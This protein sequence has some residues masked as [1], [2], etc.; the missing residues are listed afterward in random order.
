MTSFLNTKC[1]PEPRASSVRCCCIKAWFWGQ[2]HRWRDLSFGCRSTNSTTRNRIRATELAVDATMDKAGIPSGE[3]GS[4]SVRQINSWHSYMYRTV[5]IHPRLKM[6]HPIL[7][8]LLQE[9][10]ELHLAVPFPV[11]TGKVF[12]IS[13]QNI[14]FITKIF[15]HGAMRE[16]SAWGG[17]AGVAPILWLIWRLAYCP[18]KEKK[19]V[20]H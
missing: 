5:T 17:V 13:L 6:R 4:L 15:N 10:A 19:T 18:W 3:V 14:A 7:F 11:L 8:T 2:T 9:A 12:I 16:S 20:F 1:L